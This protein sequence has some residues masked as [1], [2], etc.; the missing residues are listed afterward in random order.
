M[1]RTSPEFLPEQQSG[2]DKYNVLSKE[3]LQKMDMGI[4]RWAGKKHD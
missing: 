4:T 3:R 1:R 2:S